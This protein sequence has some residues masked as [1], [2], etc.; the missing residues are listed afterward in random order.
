MRARQRVTRYAAGATLS[1]LIPL[2][3][4]PLT[5]KVLGPADYGMFAL[6]TAVTG[7]GT[8]LA[9]LGSTFLVYRFGVEADE[10]NELITGLCATATIVVITVS[11][12]VV[13]LYALLGDRLAS[14]IST[15]M[16]VLAVVAMVL[17]P[18]WVIATDL[19]VLDGRAGFFARSMTAQALVSALVTLLSLYLFD[20]DRL[21]L[22]AG[23]A[24][25]NATAAGFASVVLYPYLTRGLRREWMSEQLKMSPYASLGAIAEQAATLIERFTISAY[26]T[27]G[28]LGLYTHSQRYKYAASIGTKSVGRSVFPL[29]LGEARDTNTDFSTTKAAWTPVYI[30]LTLVGITAALVGDVAISLLTNDRFTASYTF[31]A[32]WFV[33]L[34]VREAAKPQVAALYAFA[35]GPTAAKAN[36]APALLGI[37]VIVVAVPILGAIGALIAHIS[38]QTAYWVVIHVITRRYRPTPFRDHWVIAGSALILLALG[39]K[40]TADTGLSASL[41]VLACFVVACLIL[42]RKDL[43]VSATALLGADR[44]IEPE[45]VDEVEGEERP[46]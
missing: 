22:F 14:G 42:G 25:A 17:S 15:P 20:L 6:V 10:R 36:I 39:V 32:L 19:V 18:F 2:F 45:T 9:T 3:I 8:V 4:L 5:T 30:A 21:S 37:G 1:S 12:L 29:M 33:Y 44:R 28:S 24:G 11:A 26:S 43:R 41:L 46:L 38:V 27:L 13:V 34:L 35:E 7:F 31:V 16:V 40:L 23:Y